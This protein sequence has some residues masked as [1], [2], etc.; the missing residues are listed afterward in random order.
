MREV[1]YTFVLKLP[2]EDEILEGEFE[3]GLYYILEGTG[4]IDNPNGTEFTVD[5]FEKVV[6]P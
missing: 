6:A 2:A 3:D 1:H 5:L 4:H